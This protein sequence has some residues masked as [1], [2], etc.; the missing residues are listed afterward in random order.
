MRDQARPGV[1]RV[2]TGEIDLH[3]GFRC[4]L[5]R[6]S[7]HAL[8]S[9]PRFTIAIDIDVASTDEAPHASSPAEYGTDGVAAQ[10]PIKDPTLLPS[11][12]NDETPRAILVKRWMQLTQDVLPAIAAQC[13]WPISQDHCFMRVCLDTAVGAPWHTIVKRPAIRYSSREQLAAAIAVAEALV[14]APEKLAALN[15][16]SIRWRRQAR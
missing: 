6:R 8:N 12:T 16:Q 10:N 3:E 14:S 7:F 15:A 9:Q 13:E 5:G 4:Q 2:I 1:K 11:M